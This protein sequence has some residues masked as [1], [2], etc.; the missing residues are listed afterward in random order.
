MLFKILISV[1]Q[2][3]IEI[4]QFIVYHVLSTHAIQLYLG[5]SLKILVMVIPIDHIDE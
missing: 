2:Q 1:V 3:R 5:S 4:F